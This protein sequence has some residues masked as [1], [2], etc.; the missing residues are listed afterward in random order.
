[1]KNDTE[2]GI[3]KEIFMM[4]RIIAAL[5][6]LIRIFGGPDVRPAIAGSVENMEQYD[7]R[8]QSGTAYRRSSA[9]CGRTLKWRRFSG[10]RDEWVNGLGLNFEE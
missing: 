1:M 9:A 7:V 3:K 10:Y 2:G 8:I 5:L 6:S 4:K